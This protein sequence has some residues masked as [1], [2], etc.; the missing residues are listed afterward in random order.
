MLD[1]VIQ[2]ASIGDLRID[3]DHVTPFAQSGN[4]AKNR[5]PGFGPAPQSTAL[6]VPYGESIFGRCT[7]WS[8]EGGGVGLDGP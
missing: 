7:R 6:T 1:I 8:L 5:L 3:G 4:R 2:H